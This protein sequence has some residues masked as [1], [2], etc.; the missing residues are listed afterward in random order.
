VNLEWGCS[1]LTYLL[2]WSGSVG[3]WSSRPGGLQVGR[4]RRLRAACL[5][6]WAGRRQAADQPRL[7][8]A[9]LALAGRGV[10][11]LPPPRRPLVTGRRSRVSASSRR[12]STATAVT[13]PRRRPPN[14]IL[15]AVSRVGGRGS[16]VMCLA[17]G[18]VGWPDWM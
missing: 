16:G 13:A 9:G 4:S 6:A 7:P 3:L 17:S 10:P 14:R 15:L 18:G 11:L 2:E 1:V 5:T 12:R 8:A